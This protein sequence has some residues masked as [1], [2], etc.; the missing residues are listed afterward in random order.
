M[1]ISHNYF[2]QLAYA[3]K[4]L[5]IANKKYIFIMFILKEKRKEKR[6]QKGKTALDC[7]QLNYKK[8]NDILM[9]KL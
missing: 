2:L 7:M 5:V 9:L 4:L 1:T 3:N 6:K 8:L